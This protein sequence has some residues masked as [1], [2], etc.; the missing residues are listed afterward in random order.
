MRTRTRFVHGVND[1]IDLIGCTW[2]Q[3]DRKPIEQLHA[4]VESS[5]YAYFLATFVLFSCFNRK[6]WTAETIWAGTHPPAAM[7][8]LLLPHLVDAHLARRKPPLIASDRIHEIAIEVI[9]EIDQ[10]LAELSGTAPN[11]RPLALAMRTWPT[12]GRSLNECWIQ[13]FPQLDTLKLGGRLAP[14][15]AWREH[16]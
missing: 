2:S 10:G 4:T 12:Y 16:G 13:A 7:R 11:R 5:L 3:K 1:V 8:E 15:D 6:S 9:K 14:P